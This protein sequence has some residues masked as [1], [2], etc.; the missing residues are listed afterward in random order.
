MW[1]E[2]VLTHNGMCRIKDDRSWW[3]WCSWL[4]LQA[5]MK[6]SL[7]LEHNH[8]GNKLGRAQDHI[9]QKV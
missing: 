9:P 6:T 4:D 7:D 2:G 8:H 3:W 1:K 5:R